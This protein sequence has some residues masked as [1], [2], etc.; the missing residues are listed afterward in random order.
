MST[1]TD[2]T[3]IEKVRAI[4]ELANHPNTPQHEAETAF[5]HAQKLITKY[6]LDESALLDAQNIEEGIE[7]A[8]IN[9]VGKYAL[10][11]LSVCAV[12]AHANSCSTYR[13]NLYDD[14]WS[15]NR[16]GRLVRAQ[17]GYKL[18]IYGTAKDIFATQVLWQAVEA[19]GLRT[20]PKGDRAFR[21]SWW[22]G[23]A[24]GIAKSLDNATKQIIQETGDAGVALVLRDRFKRA[25]EEMRANV[26]LRSTRA[27]SF[28]RSDAYSA[29]RSAGESFSTNGVGRG[30]IGAIGR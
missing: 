2:Q 27:S 30:A 24:S 28:S 18:V 5:T 19:L 22:H 16:H 6:N 9:I 20:I 25:D 12:V 13:T 14:K 8:V 23:F 26:R 7:K 10:R 17:Q 11:R 1:N 4:L 21:N 3:I 15:E 29:G